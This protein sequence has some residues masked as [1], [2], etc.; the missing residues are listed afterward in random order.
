MYLSQQHFYHWTNATIL[1]SSGSSSTHFTVSC[2]DVY[3]SNGMSIRYESWLHSYQTP[4][5][6]PIAEHLDGSSIARSSDRILD[7]DPRHCSLPHH[8]MLP[9]FCLGPLRNHHC[10]AGTPTLRELGTSTCQVVDDCGLDKTAGA[11]KEMSRNHTRISQK[12]VN[13]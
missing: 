9:T 3:V 7:L 1:A 5:S 11:L 8:M 4:R 12:V 10:C 6:Q 2:Q 13:V